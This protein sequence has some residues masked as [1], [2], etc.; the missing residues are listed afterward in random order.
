MSKNSLEL[1]LIIPV[2]L[3]SVSVHETAHG[4]MAK[5]LG[6]MTAYVMGRLTLN[7]L[8]H[9]DI[10]GSVIFP[11][12]L[13]IAGAPVIGWAK[14]VPIN[15]YN[16][17][18]PKKDM[19]WVAVAGVLANVILSIICIL[20]LK[21]FVEV[22]LG[23]FTPVL[24]ILVYAVQ[25]NLVLFAFNLIPI[26]PL[27]GSRIVSGLL[28]E[29]YAWKFNR[30][31]PFGIFIILILVYLNILNFVFAPVFWIYGKLLAWLGIV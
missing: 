14:P 5:K 17:K 10:F 28:P 1:L 4:W 15:P 9:I 18:N 7:P 22:D 25:I 8:K 24:K 23:P 16:L 11:L 13:A 20:L 29:Q 3:F 2:L 27:D 21:I 30:I 31:E 19:I 26:P 6:D 12:L